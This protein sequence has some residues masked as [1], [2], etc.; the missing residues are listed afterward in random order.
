MIEQA[1]L[2][3]LTIH[4]AGL[5]REP[6]EI[7][8]IVERLAPAY[9]GVPLTLREL[10]RVRLGESPLSQSRAL[11]GQA[12]TGTR[13]RLKARDAGQGPES[14]FLL[15]ELDL[16]GAGRVGLALTR[17][18]CKACGPESDQ[19]GDWGLFDLFD[20]EGPAPDFWRPDFGGY[21]QV[22]L[23]DPRDRAIVEGAV[24]LWA[25]ELRD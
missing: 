8:K 17:C 22:E 21:A 7:L 19:P 3:T 25:E 6:L 12:W 4:R 15:P 20:L 1:D 24:Y 5:W 18:C 9:D 16:P 11:R 13:P 23:E 2:L 10:H 14:L